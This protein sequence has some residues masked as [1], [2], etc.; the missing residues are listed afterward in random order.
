MTYDV[1][2]DPPTRVTHVL[3]SQRETTS[4]DEVRNGERVCILQNIT[5][6]WEAEREAA[7]TASL[8]NPIISVQ[9]RQAREFYDEV[10][11]SLISL[12][13]SNGFRSFP[14]LQE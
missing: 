6:Y 7:I 2:T 10:G 13:T 4:R 5:A 12:I 11:F 1:I 8:I 3:S 9:A 14:A